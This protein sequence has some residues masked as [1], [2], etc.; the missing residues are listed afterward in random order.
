MFVDV[1]RIASILEIQRI[2][3]LPFSGIVLVKEGDRVSQGQL[4]KRLCLKRS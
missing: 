2:R 1:L 4:L 3:Q